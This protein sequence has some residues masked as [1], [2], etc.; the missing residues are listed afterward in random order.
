M[1]ASWIDTVRLSRRK[2]RAEAVDTRPGMRWVELPSGTLRVRTGGHGGPVV[3][4]ITDPPN[5]IEHHDRV[6]ELLEGWARPVCAELP[7]GGFSIPARSLRFTFDDA[8]AAVA[9]LLEELELGPSV[10]AF[11]CGSAYIALKVAAERPELVSALALIQAPAWREEVQW[12]RRLDKPPVMR[13]PVL[14]QL[15]MMAADR[16]VARRWYDKALPRD[17]PDERRRSF[18]DPALEALRAGGAFCLASL[19]QGMVGAR[20][21]QPVDQPTLAV[22]GGAD[23]THRRSDSRS[24]AEHA[25]EARFVEFP[26]AGHFPDLEEPERVSEALRDLLRRSL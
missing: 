14:G 10:L 19:F 17:V 3:V 25:P 23:R 22:W 1:N 13:A 16:A 21:F 2:P 5:V 4:S 12:C 6:F 7:G 11:S 26:E 18:V 15:V 20:G 9:E 8:A 24:I